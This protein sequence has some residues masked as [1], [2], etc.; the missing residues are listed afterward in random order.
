MTGLR[1]I[2]SHALGITSGR[3]ISPDLSTHPHPSRELPHDHALPPPGPPPAWRPP[4]LHARDRPPGHHPAHRLRRRRRQSM[5]PTSVRPAGHRALVALD[6]TVV[7]GG[8]ASPRRPGR[9]R[10]QG[11]RPGHPRPDRPRPDRGPLVGPGHPP[12]PRVRL[13]RSS[14]PSTCAP[15]RPQRGPTPAPACSTPWPRRP[16][17]PPT[18][19]PASPWAACCSG[20]ARA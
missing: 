14:R 12:G 1:P 3:S 8:R 17:P 20:A 7:R 4:P 15:S 2:Q 11:R 6:R 19:P 10:G 5:R 18:T 9:G 13:S 16:P